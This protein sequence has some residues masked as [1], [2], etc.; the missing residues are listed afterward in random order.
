[1]ADI[2]EISLDAMSD[3]RLFEKLASE[4]MR[5]EGYPKIIP[6][7]GARDKGRDAVLQGFYISLGRTCT[8]FQ[9]TLQEY[10]PGKIDETIATLAKEKISYQELV[11]VTRYNISTETYDKM[12]ERAKKKHGVNLKIYDRKTIVN[13]LSD[14]T[15][16]IFHRHFPD[17]KTQIVD[18]TE[19]R[20]LLSEEAANTLESSMLKVSLTFTFSE[21][22]PR[23]R[24]A[25]FDF[26]ILGLFLESPSITMTPADIRDKYSQAVPG[27]QPPIEQINAAIERL[28]KGKLLARQKN[29]FTPTQLAKDKTARSVIKANKATESLILDIL[30]Q[31]YKIAN[32]KPA[33]WDVEIVARNTR[34]VLLMLFRLSGLELA[35]RILR[36]GTPAAAYVDPTKELVDAAKRQLAPEV[37]EFLI[38][39]ISDILRNPTKDQAQTLAN[40]SFA[41][42][43]V[44]IMRLDP[45]L[46]EFQ[47]K[48]L[49]NK[50]FLLDTDF[51]LDCL[52]PECPQAVSYRNLLSSLLA[53]G[54]RVIVPESSLGE[55]ITHAAISPKTYNYFGPRLL[56]LPE[57]F[58]HECV[59]NVFVKGYYYGR[60]KG[61]LRR[62]VDFEKYLRNFFEPS[63]PVPF[64]KKVVQ[65]VSQNK[66][67]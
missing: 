67:R 62:N 22:A 64:I 27:H 9:Y 63:A 3:H 60:V 29:G 17:V 47:A 51:I 57:P 19:R 50:I 31:M 5:D 32:E 45:E 56:S 36:E 55:C 58:V 39:V 35:S 34:D 43:G 10:I 53:L 28:M 12:V 6:L 4:I 1:M 2:I 37:G 11:I 24:K 61:S 16:G 49:S 18:L 20:P 65:T 46:K 44:Q 8:A 48:S 33:Q 13:R 41:Y 15:N 40:W 14:Y 25:I 66:L 26:L 7:G 54:C 59:G 30:D 42:L 23:A 38:S 52:V 21:K